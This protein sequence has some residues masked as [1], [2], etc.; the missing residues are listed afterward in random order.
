MDV[1]RLKTLWFS[2]AEDASESIIRVIDM[3]WNMGTAPN[4]LSLREQLLTDLAE[5]GLS[6]SVK[7]PDYDETFPEHVE[8]LIKQHPEL[9]CDLVLKP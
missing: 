4:I 3:F 6:Q 9:E 8:D 7:G 1:K 2:K 5:S